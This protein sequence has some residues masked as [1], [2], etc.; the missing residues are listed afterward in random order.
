M[1]AKS[2]YVNKNKQNEVVQLSDDAEEES[3]ENG[4][5]RQKL[6][7]TNLTDEHEYQ[8]KESLK[9]CSNREKRSM[10]KSEFS[11]EDSEDDDRHKDY[12]N[13]DNLDSPQESFYENN[14]ETNKK[15]IATTSNKSKMTDIQQTSNDKIKIEK[16][17]RSFINIFEQN[18]TLWDEFKEVFE[19][20]SYSKTKI[21]N[22]QKP[23][24][25]SQVI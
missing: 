25:I 18:L 20:T 5:K 21:R 2:R 17:V 9:R 13:E 7:T 12:H 14:E 11:S 16:L 22:N 15:I 6:D 24:H 23:S 1:S 4:N 10:S 19:S 8:R 3:S